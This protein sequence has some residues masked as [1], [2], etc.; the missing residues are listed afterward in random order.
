MGRSLSVKDICYVSGTRADYGLMRSTL[1]QIQNNPKC[2]LSIAVTGMHLLGQYGKTVDEIENH[3]F[4]INSRIPVHLSGASGDEMAFALADQIRGFT[5]AW[6]Q[7]KPDVVLLLGDRG[8]MLAAAI[9]AVHLNIHVTHIHGGERT[10]TIDESIRHAISKLA[11]YHCVATEKSKQRLLKMGELDEHISVTGAPGLDEILSQERPTRGS[12]C[13][14]YGLDSKQPFDLLLFHPVV[15]QEGKLMKQMDIVLKAVTCECKQPLVFLPNADAG[16]EEIR[17]VIQKYEKLGAIKTITHAP[18]PDYLA[19]LYYADMLIG[20]SSSGIIEAASLSTP[21]VNVGQRQ[22]A[23]ERNKNTI[24]VGI[25]EQDIM[26][27]IKIA[28]SMISSD[29]TNVY[30]NGHAGENITLFLEEL[31]LKA[32]DLEKV[33]AF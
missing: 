15:Q 20:N 1:H 14:A 22:N 5:Q 23:R 13:N 12:I 2:R 28:R 19:L 25:V 4:R 24:D 31:D 11:H 33:N 26:G 8:E 21:V 29:W 32:E 30:G 27:A 9:A 18:R 16:A 10:G 7:N 3:G 6:I 17:M